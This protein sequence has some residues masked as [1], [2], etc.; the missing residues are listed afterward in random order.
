MWK[1]LGGLLIVGLLG[2]AF[3]GGG[4]SST[5]PPASNSELDACYSL[6]HQMAEESHSRDKGWLDAQLD[7]CDSQYGA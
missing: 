6:A 5:D 3:G 4:G 7:F 2:I 1:V